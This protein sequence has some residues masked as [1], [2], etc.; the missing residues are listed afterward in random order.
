[1]DLL[2]IIALE[3]PNNRWRLETIAVILLILITSLALLFLADDQFFFHPL[4]WRSTLPR[5]DFCRS[6]ILLCTML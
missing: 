1:M 4:F 2:W 5:K 6:Q 3:V